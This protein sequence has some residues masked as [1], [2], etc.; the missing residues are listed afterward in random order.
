ME[1]GLSKKKMRRYEVSCSTGW[2]VQKK[3]LLRTPPPACGS[4][5][6]YKSAPPL[7]S[8]GCSPPEKR[9]SD[10]SRSTNPNHLQNPRN[11][12]TIPQDSI[13]PPPPQPHP[14]P[15]IRN[16]QIPTNPDNQPAPPQL[17]KPPISQTLEL[18]PTQ[19]PLESI[20]HPAD[21]ETN[22]TWVPIQKQKQV[23]QDT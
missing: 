8:D 3:G 10:V 19:S 11:Q 9:R 14:K 5:F 21:S 16:P 13:F 4:E 18:P 6:P 22:R 20:K 17:Q 1:L 23:P 2:W 7:K 15:Q 12:L